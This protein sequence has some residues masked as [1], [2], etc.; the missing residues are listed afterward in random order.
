MDYNVYSEFNS[1]F[2][3]LLLEEPYNTNE[4]CGIIVNEI[5]DYIQE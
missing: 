5:E 3:A 4:L 2:Y 1:D